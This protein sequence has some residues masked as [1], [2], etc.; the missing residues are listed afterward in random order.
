VKIQRQWVVTAGK[1]TNMYSKKATTC[2]GP[3]QVVH[4]IISLWTN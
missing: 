4:Y 1:Q 3:K 2:F